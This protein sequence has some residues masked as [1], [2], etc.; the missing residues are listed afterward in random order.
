ML[1][2]AMAHESAAA[3]QVKAQKEMCGEA[4]EV[5]KQIEGAIMLILPVLTTVLSA[6]GHPEVGPMIQML[7]KVLDS[8]HLLC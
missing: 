2:M 7:V 8:L 1:G 3:L 4:T 6:I 5:V